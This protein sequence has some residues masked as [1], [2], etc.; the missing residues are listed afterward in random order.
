M[1]EI[2][3][4]PHGHDK[5]EVVC[6][7]RKVW[8]AVPQGNKPNGKDDSSSK[9]DDA[10]GSGRGAVPPVGSPGSP[11]KPE[12]VF[13]PPPFVPL[14]AAPIGTVSLTYLARASSAEQLAELVGSLS[15]QRQGRS[16]ALN[17]TIVVE[18][19]GNVVNLDDLHAKFAPLG[20]DAKVTVV[21]VP[22]DGR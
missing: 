2:T 9:P 20:D 7:D 1:A 3:I 17:E 22:T 4:V 14:F 13:V 21:L 5:F 15:A 6:G 11:T 18:L 8:I 16:P 19:P 10:D 12:P